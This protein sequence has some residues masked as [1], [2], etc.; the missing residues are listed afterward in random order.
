MQLRNT[1]TFEASVN[2]YT[3]RQ[4]EDALNG[5]KKWRDWKNKLKNK[6]NNATENNEIV[7]AA[8]DRMHSYSAIGRVFLINKFH[9]VK[10]KPSV[11]SSNVIGAASSID[12]NTMVGLIINL[13]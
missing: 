6:Y 4:I 13:S 11:F 1:F 12:F 10:P 8:G 2:D 9:K 5:T 3:I 7:W